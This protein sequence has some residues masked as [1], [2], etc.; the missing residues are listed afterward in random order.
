M[1]VAGIEE[2]QHR[3]G[4]G[5]HMR[6]IMATTT[7]CTRCPMVMKQLDKHGIGYEAVD[8]TVDDTMR[9]L[10]VD[11][12]GYLQAPV[13]LLLDGADPATATVLDHT[14]SYSKNTLLDWDRRAAQIA[15]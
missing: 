14:G 10:V 9:S 2:L 4:K 8:I 11:T 13:F 3:E 12:L 1:Y 6:I 5:P 15:A 7:D